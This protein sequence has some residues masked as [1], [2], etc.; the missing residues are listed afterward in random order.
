MLTTPKSMR[1]QIVLA[2]RSNAGKSSLLNLLCGN[3]TAITSPLPGT[4]TDVVEKAMEF[5]P[6]GAVLFLDTAGFDDNTPL[7]QARM[8]KT[9]TAL[10]RA[11]ILIIVSK[12]GV[13]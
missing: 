12:P 9:A 4:T 8:S 11:D 2:G 3:N 13:W 5:R 10:T 1:L 7:G 6:F